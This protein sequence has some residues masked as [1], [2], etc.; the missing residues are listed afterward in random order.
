MTVLKQN[1][2]LYSQEDVKANDKN[3]LESILNTL[4][5]I[6]QISKDS[7]HYESNVYTF[8]S[9]SIDLIP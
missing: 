7:I 6:Q 4:V 8:F 9:F 1:K 2:M 3:D 5:L